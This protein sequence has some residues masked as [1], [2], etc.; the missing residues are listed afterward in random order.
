MNKTKTTRGGRLQ[1]LLDEYEISPEKLAGLVEM[2]G[3]AVRA[4]IKN[5]SKPYKSTIEKLA[6]ALGT[7]YDYLENGKGEALPDGKIKLKNLSEK[8]TE[9]PWE[10]EAWGLAKDQIK[11]KDQQLKKK[12][13][14]LEMLAVSFD[15]VTK[16]MQDSG[17]S[18][19]QVAKK[20]GT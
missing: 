1:H 11:E 13:D 14:I 10:D 8:Q 12:D 17:M 9:N 2:S 6:S 15:R 16:M 7:S 18:F 5:E 20:T 4:I 19:L 3:Q